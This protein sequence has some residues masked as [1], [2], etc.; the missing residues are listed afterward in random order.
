MFLKD[1][2]IIALSRGLFVRLMFAQR[3]ALRKT[4]ANNFRFYCYHSADQTPLSL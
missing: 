4:P 3:T 1:P 2:G